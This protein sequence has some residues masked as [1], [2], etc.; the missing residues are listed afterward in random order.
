[1][2]KKILVAFLLLLFVAVIADISQERAIKNGVIE[3][4]V[5]GGEEKELSLLLDMEGIW[6]DEPYR[7]E[8]LPAQPTKEE[9]EV[10]FEKAISDIEQ[11][12]C[13]IEEKIPLQ[14][15]YVEGVVEAEWLFEPYGVIDAEGNIRQEKLEKGGTTVNAQVELTCGEYEK[16]YSFAFVVMPKELSKEELVMQQLENW[17]NQ[18]MSMEGV[19]EIQLPDEINGQ[20]LVWSEVRE[21]RTPQILLLELVALILLWI[22]SKRKKMQDEQKRIQK[23]EKEYPEIVNQLSLLLGAG[24]TTRQAWNKLTAQYQWKRKA[25]MIE[26]K[27]VYEAIVRMTRRFSE[28]ESERVV[29]QQFSQEIPAPC[30]H[31]L[32]RILLGNLEKGAQGICSRLEEE[33]RTAYEKRIQ[34]AKKLGE[35]ASTKMLLPLMLMMVI[36]MGIVMLPALIEFQI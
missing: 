8:V 32:M 17:M 12:F 36:V 29:Y 24:M 20:K 30:F 27:E 28:G 25:G 6:V 22:I 9:T 33:G 19:T 2:K 4:A 5:V 1:M 26:E 13:E 11:A 7:L 18:Q 3:R 35:E 14:T 21:Y 34:Q 31:K 16:I 10:Y 15:T 23:I